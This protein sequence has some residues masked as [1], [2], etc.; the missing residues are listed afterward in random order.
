MRTVR[1]LAWS[2][3][4]LFLIGTV[5]QL[6]DFLNLYA[7]PPDTSNAGTMVEQRLA[8]QDYRIAIWPIFF[9][10]NLSFGVAFVAL[11]GLG[12][13]LASWLASSDP[14]RIII[15]T[16]L[17]IAGVLGAVAQLILIGATQVTIDITYCD[18]GFKETE[19]VSQIWAQ[20][21]AEGASNWLVNGALV[22]AGIG[23]LAVDASFRDRMPPAWDILS[24]LT[25]IGSIAAVAVGVLRLGEELGLYLL[26]F[27][28]GVLVPIWAIWLGAS[29]RGGPESEL[30]TGAEAGAA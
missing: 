15:P 20:M 4:I 19:I 3:G 5:L 16:S 1:W 6:V 24:W 23:V 30:E 27:V 28:S 18:C 11:A 7:T 29:L 2:V 17:G 22:L 8:S 26:L 14:R 9:L 12:L 13:G 21:L 25:A 10:S